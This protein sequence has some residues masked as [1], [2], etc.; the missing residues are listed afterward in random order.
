MRSN[1]K[2]LKHLLAFKIISEGVVPG[3]KEFPSQL[4]SFFSCYLTHPAAPHEDEP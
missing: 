4:K 2:Q 1:E 3:V